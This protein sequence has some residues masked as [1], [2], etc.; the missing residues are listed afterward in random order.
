MNRAVISVGSNIDP[1]SNIV[2]AVKL[3]G[4]IVNILA[5]APQVKTKPIG[6]L[7][8]RDFINGAFLIETSMAQTALKDQL[9]EIEKQLGRVK[10]VEKF[11]PR[12]IDLDIAV[13]NGQIVDK[14]FYER[15]FLRDAILILWPDL[16][17]EGNKE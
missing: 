15:D 5:Q 13:W 16:K 12:T 3:L 11:G 7:N 14:D 1:F 10:Q 4:Q 8:Q 17:R 9:K 6:I 2:K